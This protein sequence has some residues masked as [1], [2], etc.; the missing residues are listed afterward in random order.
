M[1]TFRLKNYNLKDT[2]A[3]IATFP[4]RSALGVVRISGSKSLDIVSRIFKPKHNKK[5]KK[6][7]TYTLHYGWIVEK[8]RGK[9]EYPVIDEVLVGL[10]RAPHSFTCEDVVEISCHGGIIVLNK[11]LEVLLTE[12]ARLAL[13]GEFTYRAMVNGRIDLLQAESIKDIVEARSEEGLKLAVKQLNGANTRNI[14]IIKE[15]IKEMFINIEAFINFPEDDVDISSFNL[16]GK[17]QSVNKMLDRVLAGSEQARILKEGLR[18][19]ICG[20]ANAGKSTLFNCLLKEER[21]IVS[22][23]AGTT[24]DVIEESISIKG[25]PLR[26]YDTAGI[27]EPRDLTEKKALEKTNRMFDEADLVILILDG[28]RPLNKDDIFLLNKVK[29]KNSIFVINKIDLPEKMKL[30]PLPGLKARQVRLSALKNRGIRRLEKTIFSSVYRRGLNQQDMIF[31]S[32][33]QREVLQKVKAGVEQAISFLNKGHTIDFAGLA[34]KECL[35]NLGRISGEVLSEEV[36][37]SIFSQFC[38]GK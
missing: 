28:S 19:V 32:N 8:T 10:M 34:L 30:G 12:G 4:S 16:K 11:I 26:I 7:K 36:L 29:D 23:T 37:A 33:Y 17:L 3:A 18:C 6:V 1:H 27:L 2:I 22:R 35:D 21:V 5:L 20:K 25:V 13:P 38:I 9:K 24:R 15:K 31:L 14:E